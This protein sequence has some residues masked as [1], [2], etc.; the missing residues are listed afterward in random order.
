[1]KAKPTQGI[2]CGTGRSLLSPSPRCHT[3]PVPV[4]ASHLLAR[5]RDCSRPPRDYPY[6][7]A[8]VNKVLLS[9]SALILTLAQCSQRLIARSWW[10]FCVQTEA[11]AYTAN[12]RSHVAAESPESQ[13]Q[14]PLWPIPINSAQRMRPEP[15]AWRAM[16][17]DN[18]VD[19]IFGTLKVNCCRSAQSHHVNDSVQVFITPLVDNARIHVIL[20]MSVVDLYGRR[21]RSL[22]CLLTGSRIQ[23]KP[24][25]A[26]S[27]TSSSVNQYVRN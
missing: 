19:S 4:F 5:S 21:G 26:K 14:P 24:N 13:C 9:A 27:F 15:T 22:L 17:I 11:S 23:L 25:F 3:N 12:G 2:R 10:S 7:A 18:G 8:K 1:M 16:Q 6:T 20:K